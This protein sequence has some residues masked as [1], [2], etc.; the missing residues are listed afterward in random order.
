MDEPPLPVKIAT[1]PFSA[2]FSS[3]GLAGS[4]YPLSC[5][6]AT[7][8]CLTPEERQRKNMRAKFDYVLL[9]NIMFFCYF[10]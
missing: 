10:I 4:I 6:G 2:L 5:G 8:R 1:P 9:Y 3:S 7:I